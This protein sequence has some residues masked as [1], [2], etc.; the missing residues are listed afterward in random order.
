M[1]TEIRNNVDQALM[2]LL[3]DQAD[4]FNLYSK[5]P[6]EMEDQHIYEL[7]ELTLDIL[8]ETKRQ[9]I[10]MLGKDKKVQLIKQILLQREHLPNKDCGKSPNYYIDLLNN[11]V[12]ASATSVKSKAEQLVDLFSRGITGASKS[13][14]TLKDIISEL[15]V[16]CQCQ[17]IR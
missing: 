11:T 13:T 14:V 12:A 2:G 15:K 6:E 8:G 16:Q 1:R 5:T 3:V 10:R 4:K 7:L 17:S 9:P